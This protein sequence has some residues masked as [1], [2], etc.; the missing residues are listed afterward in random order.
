[1]LGLWRGSEGR[2]VHPDLLD[3]LSISLHPADN[4]FKALH[5]LTHPRQPS[6]WTQPIYI[7]TTVL[8]EAGPERRGRSSVNANMYTDL[9]SSINISVSLCVCSVFLHSCV[10][11][12]VANLRDRKINIYLFEQG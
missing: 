2:T 1:M 9:Y 8:E 12:V 10:C 5:P 11:E 4:S 6:S 3:V 7:P